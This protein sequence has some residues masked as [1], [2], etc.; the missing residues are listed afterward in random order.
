MSQAYHTRFLD[1]REVSANSCSAPVARSKKAASVLAAAGLRS[2][3]LPC[4]HHRRVYPTRRAMQEN[5]PL[6]F[7]NSASRGVANHGS[8][9]GA[10][11]PALTKAG[12]DGKPAF[13][14]RENS[15]SRW[16]LNVKPQPPHGLLQQPRCSRPHGH[17]CDPEAPLSVSVFVLAISELEKQQW[18]RSILSESRDRTC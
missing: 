16:P 14:P 5:R 6:L 7:D 10:G 15:S 1:G 13:L 3:E 8:E 9:A 17:V 11:S 2:G 18:T 12:L 4:S